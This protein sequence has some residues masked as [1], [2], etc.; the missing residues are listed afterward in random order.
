MIFS[1]DS[2]NRYESPTLTL[3]NP[4]DKP[5]GLI[6]NYSDLNIDVCFNSISEISFKVNK[7][8]DGK[9]NPLYTKLQT[10]REI[11]VSDLKV[12][13]EGIN[14][15]SRELGYFIIT[16]VSEECSEDNTEKTIT[17]QSC[18]CELN[19]IEL[20][21]VDGV[22]Q[23]YE[24]GNPNCLLNQIMRRIPKWTLRY[25]D[26]TIAKVHRTFE[27]GKSTVYNFLMS[28]FAESYDAIVEYDILNR[29][30]SVYNKA[31]YIDSANQ[32]THIAISMEDIIDSITTNED[33]DKLFTAL[34]VPSDE[35]LNIAT[36]NPSR[37][38]TLYNF[39]YFMNTEWLPQELIDK[40]N[41]LKKARVSAQGSMGIHGYQ[42][43]VA[44]DVV[45]NEDESVTV[46][47][48]S[49]QITGDYYIATHNYNKNFNGSDT[50][51]LRPT[52][53]TVYM[54]NGTQYVNV[55]YNDM[56]TTKI[57]LALLEYEK[58]KYI[59]IESILDSL[60]NID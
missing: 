20:H 11:L 34:Y 15:I 12:R 45:L 42:E 55:S 54:W 8:I 39:D 46:F 16:G 3:C 56:I 47:P 14:G 22:Y 7:K 26:S 2:F 1:F 32:R 43:R 19:K 28:E 40:L 59:T 23:M 13:Q 38:N 17:A 48:T 60:S 35:E 50:E 29:E 41:E 57:L 51:I 37:E 44:C 31:T 24:S 9:V 10:K 53:C 33:I 49:G 27:F 25:V 30:I 21:Y 58:E 36:V 5:L 52:E 4:N 18:E 6:S